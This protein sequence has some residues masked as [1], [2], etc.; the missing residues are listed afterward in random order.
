MGR[1]TLISFLLAI[2]IATYT[3]MYKRLRDI[4]SG[5]TGVNAM[6][7]LP[8]PRI[9]V[10]IAII[11]AILGIA[12]DLGASEVAS[13]FGFGLCFAM[14]YT[15]VNNGVPVLVPKAT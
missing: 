6:T 13:M 14:F 2:T 8:K 1:G 7:I 4:K 12:N 15:A 10:Y 3:D 9:Y 11:W 5:E